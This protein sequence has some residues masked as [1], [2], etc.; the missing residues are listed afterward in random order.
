MENC[1]PRNAQDRGEDLEIVQPR[2]PVFP[3]WETYLEALIL[4][5]LEGCLQAALCQELHT[6]T[7]V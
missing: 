7:L 1:H 3:L 6:D 4:C 5:L 2:V